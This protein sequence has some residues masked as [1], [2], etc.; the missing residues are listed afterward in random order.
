[1]NI[2]SSLPGNP[3]ARYLRTLTAGGALLLLS[4]CVSFDG[5]SSQAQLK[6]LSAD[7]NSS[8]FPNQSGTWPDAGWATGIGGAQLQALIAEGWKNNPSLQAAAA[9]IS[10]ARAIADA[11]G[12]NALPAVNASLDST[13]Q[14]FTENGMVPRP[15]A[16]SFRSNNQLA[17]N[18][19][20]ELDFW[21]KHS[22]EMRAALSQEKVAQAE[23]Q[24]ARLLLSSAIARSWLQ[25]ARQ[26]AQLEFSQRQLALRERLDQLTQQRV[27]AGLDT[28]SEIQQSLLQ[29]SSLKT[30]IAQWQE[31]IALSRNQLATLIGAGPERGQQIALPA[32]QATQSSALPAQLPL[33]LLAR[34]PDIVAARWRVEASQGE[35]DLTKTQF[36]PNINLIAFAGVSSL[37]VAKLLQSGSAI[38]GAGPA[39]RLPIFEGGRLR[40]QLKSR[41]AGYDVAVASYNQSINDALRDVADQV[42]T[43]LASQAQ[44]QQQAAAEQAARIQLQLAQQRQAAGT[45]NLLTVLA[46]E[47]A[48]LG[49]QRISLDISIRR[50]DSQIMLIKALG[51]GYA[52]HS[53]QDNI[54]QHHTEAA[55]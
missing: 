52:D 26:A 46:A 53:I 40:A 10:A 12:A 30:E 27:Q 16:G 2:L 32:F 48:L 55:Q 38:V 54:A 37:G 7:S 11:T 15:L 20:Y 31:A 24:S 35:V 4:A 45:A 41:V 21:G 39:I 34:R 6:T 44:A 47:S 33:E 18:A 8:A 23:S 17:L 28:Q 22:A 13:Y 9:R 1:M 19:A 43:L 5:I 25:L 36:Y 14:R 49:Q 29:L 50:A 42:Q 51:G 3:P